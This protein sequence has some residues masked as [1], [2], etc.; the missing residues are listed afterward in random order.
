M[1]DPS[2]R[3]SCAR[4]IICSY[5]AF[6]CVPLLRLGRQHRVYLSVWRSAFVRWFVP[7]DSP[8][9]RLPCRYLPHT[10]LFLILPPLPH[11]ASAT[12]TPLLP[13]NPSPIR[14]TEPIQPTEPNRLLLMSRTTTIAWND[15]PC[16]NRCH[17]SMHFNV[18][19]HYAHLHP[20]SW[21]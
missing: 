12:P 9:S 7:C 8:M 6:V 20:K 16:A 3:P 15:S 2:V 14:Q 11:S 13:L 18:I 10:E 21:F 5:L 1:F 19:D 17:A 4:L